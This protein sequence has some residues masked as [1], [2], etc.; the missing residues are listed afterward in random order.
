MT[1]RGTARIMDLQN[2]TNVKETVQMGFSRR[3]VLKAAAAT[4][5]LGSV[6]APFV[7][8]AQQSEFT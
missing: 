7:A 1:K 2:N 3:T 6:G 5:V 4:A 8:R